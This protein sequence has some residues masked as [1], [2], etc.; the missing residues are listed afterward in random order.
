MKKKILYDGKWLQL[1]T[2]GSWEHVSRKNCTGIVIIVAKTK[3]NKLVLV[4]Q[5]R[6][7]LGKN[8]LELPAGLVADKSRFKNEGFAAAAKRELYEEAGYAAKSFKF[9][10]KGPVS[11]GLTGE[12]VDFYLASGLE[13]KHV[14][15][16]DETEDIKV[17]EVPLTG[18][19]LWLKKMGKKG[20]MVDPKIYTGL[21]FLG[22]RFKP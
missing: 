20:V 5:Y 11:P 10:A 17:H 21:Y 4:E 14:G 15:G 1:V 18:I 6:A 9:L 16:G 12:T 8:V 7:P 3:Q 19:D 13:K 2:A 22:H